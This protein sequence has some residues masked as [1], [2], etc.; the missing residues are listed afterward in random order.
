[1][2][3]VYTRGNRPRGWQLQP[4]WL[5]VPCWW[6]S[7]LSLGSLCLTITV[8]A[9]SLKSLQKYNEL[10]PF[11][12]FLY[13]EDCKLLPFPLIKENKSHTLNLIIELIQDLETSKCKTQCIIGPKNKVLPLPCYR[14]RDRAFVILKTCPNSHTLHQWRSWDLTPGLPVWESPCIWMGLE[15]S[16]GMSHIYT[17]SFQC[18]A[19]AKKI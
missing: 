4:P 9:F 15:Q 11:C 12:P 16:E 10:G 7:Q 17:G 8:E 3:V 1:M 6:Q 19:S 13:S 2:P 5:R 14:W 18:K